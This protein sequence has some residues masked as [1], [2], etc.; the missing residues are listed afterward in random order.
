M[1]PIDWT[2]V[3][4]T[5]L[6]VLAFAVYTR[7]F[8][9]SV[10]D[11]LAAGR[12]AGRYLLAN[13]RG[14]SDS[15]LANTMAKFEIV[16]ISGFVL[17]FW[18]KVSVPV[19]LLVGISGFVVY[20]F[21]ET[22]ALTLAQ[23]LEAR[24]SRRYRLFMGGLAFLSG[25][26]NYGVFPAISA[27]FFIYFLNLPHD[28]DLGLFSVPTLALIMFGYLTV[29]VFLVTVGGQVTLMVTDC[30]EGLL[31]HAIYI[32]IVVAVFF[33]VSWSQVVQVMSAAPP[34]HS[35]IDPFNA[36]EV[37][38]FNFW[39]VLMYLATTV[40]QTMALQNKQGFNAAARTPHESR[41][42]YVLGNW[43]TYARMLMVLALGVCAVTYLKHPD[44]AA[45]AAQINAEIG[46][47]GDKYIQKQMTVPITLSHLLPAGIK[48]LF[49]AMMV[50]GLFAGDSGHMHSWGSI[51][52]QDVVLPL[53]KRPM[54]PRQHI[55][56]LRGAVIF[57]AAFA[58]VFSLLFQQ[59][60]YIALW[61]ALT[62]MVFVGGAGAAII[63]GLYWR[64]GTTQAAW[65]AQIAGSTCAIVGIFLT[66]RSG[67]GWV[68][69]TFG[70]DLANLGLVLPDRF[71]LNGMQ[72]ACFAAAVAI[73][74]YV[75]V[76]L[77]TCRAEVDLDRLLHR[78]RY[79][80]EGDRTTPPTP[81][82][83]R[84]RLKNVLGF[85]NNFT[86]GDKLASAGI[87]W[88]AI[89]LLAVNLVVS[90]WNVAFH[91]WPISWWSRY[92]LIAGVG[93]PFLIAVGTLVWFV[94]GGTKDIAAFFSAL[95]TMKRD[96]TDD[97]RVTEESPTPPPESA[98]EPESRVI[99]VVPAGPSVAAGG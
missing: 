63:G 16:L 39:F 81:L 99:P 90:I 24:Y 18:E 77:L 43:R 28:V 38:D 11:F 22:R 10:A 4:A 7:R 58:F 59:T 60:Q 76:S 71:W 15:G 45:P 98:T 74:V 35:M 78:G 32:A 95:R 36:H 83:E 54:T 47:I 34:G 53:R 84:F 92:W 57:V 37:E 21:R 19:L 69:G 94:I 97:G 75:T 40:Y 2:I 17:N 5:L 73:C 86:F 67:W 3:A 55:W 26:L 33:V 85:D 65:A 62:S 9:K 48:G 29:V 79:A 66:N 20:R 56:A 88:W 51:F 80:V 8:V 61:M 70:T 52:V 82:R 91:P 87:F 1:R 64:K 68:V 72:M 12:C 30:V 13:A 89:L 6:L 41:M 46:A 14:E 96:A 49:C 25:I 27:R 42:G 23:F 50:M 44:F 31:S 93:L